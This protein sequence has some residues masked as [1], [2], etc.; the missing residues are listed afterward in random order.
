MIIWAIIPVK[1]LR[2]S[3]SRLK[4]ILSADE[5]ADLTRN[6]LRHT[7]E[8]L[9]QVAVIQRTMVVSR[10]P[11]A[12]KIARGQGASTYGETEKQ[13][14]NMA[15]TRATHIAAAQKADCVLILPSDLPFITV[16]DVEMMIAAVKSGGGDGGGNGYYYRQRAIAICTDQNNDGTNGLLVCQP[17]GFS[18]QYGPGSFQRHLDE[19][20]RLG[21]LHNIVQS[22]GIEFDLDT[23]EDWHSYVARQTEPALTA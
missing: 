19:A 1:P 7:L 11:A 12:L 6:M 17:A 2:Y 23:E 9:D 13:D 14:M 8:V 10:D 3:K 22:P 5:R 4:N 16:E 20:E 15:L 18:F 21:M